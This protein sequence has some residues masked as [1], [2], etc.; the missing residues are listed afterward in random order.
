MAKIK[1][2]GAFFAVLFLA[3]ALASFADAAVIKGNT[4][5]FSLNKISNVVVEIDSSPK[6]T[7]VVKD[8][9]YSFTLGQGS[10]TITAMQ[11][12]GT[13]TVAKAEEKIDVKTDGEFSVD[14]ILFP[15]IDQPTIYEP[16]PAAGN[17]REL[18]FIYIV[19]AMGLFIAIGIAIRF[20]N[21]KKVKHAH[22]KESKK[23]AGKTKNVKKAEKKAE[24]KKED[25]REHPKNDVYD[26]GQIIEMLKKHGGRATQK[27]IRKEIPLSEAKISLMIAELESRGKIEKIKKGRG[28]IIILK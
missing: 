14:L 24:E 17:E 28:N 20:F 23:T 4:Y 26:S 1:S 10:Y 18:L 16:S 12:S 6:Q 19:A 22:S 9:S 2:F 8:G 13:E 21:K 11:K 25:V 3:F 27:D 5:D 7:Y 15:V